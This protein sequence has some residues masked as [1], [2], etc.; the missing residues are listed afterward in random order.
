MKVAPFFWTTDVSM[1]LI[2]S[3]SGQ[4]LV[5][6]SAR[7]VEAVAGGGAGE[8]QDGGSRS[9]DRLR[10][11]H[12]V[13]AVRTRWI[14]AVAGR[15]RTGHCRPASF[16]SAGGRDGVARWTTDLR[17]VRSYSSKRRCCSS[18]LPPLASPG[19]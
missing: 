1:L 4:N 14:P 2:F 7:Q 11:G 19:T 15:V 18:R 9:A 17:R 12:A 6:K 5:S 8:D 3:C 16:Q 13:L 10:A